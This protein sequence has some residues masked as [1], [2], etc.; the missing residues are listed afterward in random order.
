M[1]ELLQ[2][3]NLKELLATLY[4]EEVCRKYLERMRWGE[5]PFCPH[6]G[7]TKPYRRDDGRGYRCRD[8]TCRKDF[9]VT[10]KTVFENTKIPLS[11]WLAAIFLLTGHK[12]GISSAQLARD[13]GVTQKTAW[14]LNHRIRLIM[15]DPAPP[16]LDNIVEVDETYVGGKWENMN[17]GRRQKLRDYGADNKVAVMG[18]V[19]RDGKARLT[20]IG[21]SN[22][23]EMVRLNVDKNAVV[24]TDAHQGYVGLAQ[25]FAGHHS[26]NHSQS[27]YRRGIAHTN[28]VEGFFS[29]LKR[30]IYGI[31][32]QVSPKHLQRYC[33]ETS[34]R[35]NTR[36]IKD[37]DRFRMTISNVEGRLKYK[38]LIA[39]K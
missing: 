33:T 32:H 6:C 31:Y 4:D 35:Y 10:V 39:K 25:E 24:M 27:E 21:K 22:F 38:T 19:E 20:I 2:F 30:S 18:M 8:K 29:C 23:K 12:K 34:Y 15:C 5:E 17:K 9:T 13:L 11:K 16:K 7:S 3:K 1:T 36:H 26:V 37:A 28:S 14:F